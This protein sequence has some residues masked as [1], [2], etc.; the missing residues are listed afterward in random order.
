MP[1]QIKFANLWG[2]YPNTQPYVDPETDEPPAGYE[3]QCAIKVSVALQNAGIDM[4][5]FVGATV[6]LGDKRRVSVRAEELARWL[7][8][9]PASSGLAKPLAITG[10]KW[11][12]KIKGKTGI[13][14]FANY[15]KRPG[16]TERP[17]GDHI[18]LWNG[19]RLTN[20]GLL[21]TAQTFARFT[22]GLHSGPGYSDLR[23]ASEIL[24]WEL[25]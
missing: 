11:D 14:Y 4:K 6:R 24:F 21:G 15:W 9:Q 17:T 3:N 13:V 18:D 16:E 23:N 10:L 8:K 22:L 19:S 25:K 2:R 1:A 5:T 7:K 20:N 12:E